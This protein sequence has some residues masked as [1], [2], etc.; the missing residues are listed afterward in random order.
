[1]AKVIELEFG[2]AYHKGHLARLLKELQWTPQTPIRTI[3]REEEAIERWRG[4]VW[5]ELMKQAR[6]ERRLL[7]FVDESGFN[8]L[9]GVVKSYSTEGQTPVLREK[10]SRDH[11]SVMTGM[12]P[13]GKL[14]TL[15]RQESLNGLPS[16]EFLVHLLRVTGRQLL[17]IRDGSPIHR[18][19]EVTQFIPSGSSQVRLEGL[20]GY[21]PD[22]NP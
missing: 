6:R 21:A 2:V 17:V 16:M 5:P 1:M 4:V 22:P 10:L 18:R 13:E 8:L 14:Y 3:Q 7:V 20:P 19:S 11:L 12:T 15:A 9:P